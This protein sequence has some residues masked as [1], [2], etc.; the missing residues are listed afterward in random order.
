MVQ[1][2]VIAGTVGAVTLLGDIRP[3][4]PGTGPV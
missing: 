3:V 1:V 4:V 2:L